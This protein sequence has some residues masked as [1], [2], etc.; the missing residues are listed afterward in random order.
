MWR[1]KMLSLIMD[2]LL[3]KQ[4]IKYHY[5]TTPPTGTQTTRHEVW[6]NSS[7][8][9]FCSYVVTA[10]VKKKNLPLPESPL[11]WESW[12][13]HWAL[14][15][16]PSQLHKTKAPGFSWHHRTVIHQQTPAKYTTL[17]FTCKESC[18]IFKS[19]SFRSNHFKNNSWWR[20]KLS[21]IFAHLTWQKQGCFWNAW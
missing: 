18:E 2:L 19:F 16:F 1:L 12:Q 13:S 11:S 14:L 20:F 9:G 3:Q 10:R 8:W 6:R 21:P 5:F 17:E 4:Q 7:G 15:Y